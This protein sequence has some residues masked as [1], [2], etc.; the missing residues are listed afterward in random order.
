[1]KLPRGISHSIE[2]NPHTEIYQPVD[3]YIAEQD[4]FMHMTDEDREVCKRTGELWVLRWC[5][6]TPVGSC[7]IAGPTLDRVLEIA[8]RGD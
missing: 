3:A 1:M 2:H 8:D 7:C 5:P 4:L 6:D